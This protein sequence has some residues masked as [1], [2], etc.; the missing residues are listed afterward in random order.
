MMK[1]W[2]L[3][4]SSMTSLRWITLTGYSLTTVYIGCNTASALAYFF[5]LSS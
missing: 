5:K 4:S 3:Q 1:F 2:A